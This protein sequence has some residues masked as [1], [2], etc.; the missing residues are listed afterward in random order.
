MMAI[1]LEHIVEINRAADFGIDPFTKGRYEQFARHLPSDTRDVLDI[2]CSTGL[3]A[4][5]LIALRPGLKITGLDCVPERLASLDPAIFSSSICAFSQDVPLPDE[6]FCAIIAGEIIEHVPPDLVF[7]TLCEF[8]RLL[9]LK[10]SL[11]L[12]TPNPDYIRNR[13]RGT[14][15]LGGPHV[16]QHYPRNLRR[17]LEDV[18]FSGVKIRG[19]GR[20]SAIFGEYFPIRSLYGSYFIKAVKW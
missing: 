2:G 13:L 1:H 14:S 9:K 3:G 8:F 7:P 4:A 5:T 18:G 20:V 16:S 15:V 19:S 6:N 12:T 10:G 17:R 11:L